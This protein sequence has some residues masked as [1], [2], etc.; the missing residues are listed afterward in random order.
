MPVD[1]T[2][3][4][5]APERGETPGDPACCGRAP[6]ES[7]EAVCARLAAER[8][9]YRTKYQRAL[10]DFQNFQ[11]RANQS[12]AEARTAAAA[13]VIRSVLTVLDHFDLALAQDAGTATA[14]SIIRGVRVIR[15]ELGA[16]LGNHG[17][18]RIAPEANEPFDPTRH[19]AVMQRDAPGVEP[20]HIAQ[21]LQPGYAM[22][23]RVIRPA[24]VAVA[25]RG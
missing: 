2:N 14:E 19:E 20:G 18:L 23:D 4:N 5:D 21:T 25:P 24:K 15:D 13:A 6:D 17:V 9:E 10:A 3:P 7:P 16:V 1:A 11:R 22:G 8:D 12:E